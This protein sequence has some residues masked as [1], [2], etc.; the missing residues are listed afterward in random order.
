MEEA[1]HKSCNGNSTQTAK[2]CSI[3]IER[4]LTDSNN[5]VKALIDDTSLA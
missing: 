1:V 4:Y 2:E 3:F 5:Q